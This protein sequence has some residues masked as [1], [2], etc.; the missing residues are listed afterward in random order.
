MN[1]IDTIY[2]GLS[3]FEKIKVRDFCLQKLLSNKVFIENALP[4]ETLKPIDLFSRYFIEFNSFPSNDYLDLC[5]KDHIPINRK[6]DIG[7]IYFIVDENFKYCK[8]GYSKDPNKRL[9]IIETHCPF[10][11]RIAKTMIGGVKE[12]SIMH[13]RFNEHQIKREWFVIEGSLL[14][15]LKD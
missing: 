4:I 1:K 14:E 9:I 11:M 10:N 8:I 15:F 7:F 13:K 2:N 3:S 12:E 6:K 5:E